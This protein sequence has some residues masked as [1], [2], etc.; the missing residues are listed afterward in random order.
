MHHILRARTHEQAV[1]IPWEAAP[2]A[3]LTTLAFRLQC[4]LHGATT[5]LLPGLESHIICHL[6]RHKDIYK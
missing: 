4:T 5:V 6:E 1:R 2:H 3:P